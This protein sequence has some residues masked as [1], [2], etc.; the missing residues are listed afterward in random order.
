MSSEETLQSA[1]SIGEDTSQNEDTSSRTEKPADGSAEIAIAGKEN[2]RVQLSKVLVVTVFCV[3]AAAVSMATFAFTRDA[4]KAQF[5]TEVCAFVQKATK[6]SKILSRSYTFSCNPRM[7]QY[8]GFVTGIISIMQWEAQNNFAL[9]EQLSASVTTSAIISGSQFPFLTNSYFEISGGY[10]DGLS[11]IV[12]TAF[13]PFVSEEKR[14]EWETY[15]WE[16]QY[17]L[18]E[19]AHLRKIHPEHKDPLDGSFQDHEER[20]SLQDV[21]EYPS[22]HRDIFRMENGMMIREEKATNG[23]YAPVWQVAPTPAN[24]PSMVNFNIFSDPFF[25]KLCDEV[26]LY[27]AT[28]LSPPLDVDFLFDY[29]FDQNEKHEK[30]LPHAYIAEPVWD[31]FEGDHRIVGV[32]VGILAWENFLNNLIP[33]DISG[34]ICVI[35]NSCGASMTWELI[36]SH[37]L[38]LGQGDLHDHS[39]N[40]YARHANIEPVPETASDDF[41]RYTLTVYPSKSLRKEYSENKDIIYTAV[42]VI[43][44]LFTFAIFSIYDCFVGAR[45]RKT[46]ETA[47]R[48]TRIISNLFPAAVRARLL[49]DVAQH[50]Q[51]KSL[52]TGMKKKDQQQEERLDSSSTS[53]SGVPIAD[54]FPS[55]TIMFAE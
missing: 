23:I 27:N 6:K 11:G 45:Q 52:G 28:V 31:T 30:H 49:E 21:K 32:L 41:C 4:E 50:P 53:T 51:D 54:L 40:E 48:T 39:Y 34:V 3:C 35:E 1:A 12:S 19:G 16:H 18:P 46:M 8:R 43:S 47:L 24:D 38:Y 33:K 5:E 13:A 7:E 44:F 37:A 17:W 15:A 42:V 9:M 26:V 10:V 25:K 29:A 2:R 20:R 55:A 14:E 36:G 22:I